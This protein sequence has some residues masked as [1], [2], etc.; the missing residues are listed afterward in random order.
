MAITEIY[1][2]NIYKYYKD[3]NPNFVGF[4]RYVGPIM[5]YLE[6]SKGKSIELSEVHFD[7]LDFIKYYKDKDENYYYVNDPWW[8]ANNIPVFK[9]GK[10]KVK[11]L[12]LLIMSLEWD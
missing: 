5:V 7:T 11:Q 10:D 3:L 1:N 4:L 12:K 8:R 9:L 6:E 2:I